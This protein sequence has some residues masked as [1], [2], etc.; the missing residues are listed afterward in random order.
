MEGDGQPGPQVALFSDGPLLLAAKLAQMV[1]ATPVTPLDRVV[2]V[3]LEY[4]VW[5]TTIVALQ[6]HRNEGGKGRAALR[7]LHFIMHSTIRA[8]QQLISALDG[9]RDD[10]A[11]DGHDVGE[12]S[13]VKGSWDT[14]DPDLDIFVAR[15]PSMDQAA[16]SCP[17]GH[18]L[19]ESA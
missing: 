1:A 17:P 11:M 9:S 8:A 19:Q 10:A 13:E 6:F 14:D 18:A 3:D 15:G 12:E 4:K 2:S 16:V 5:A 7:E